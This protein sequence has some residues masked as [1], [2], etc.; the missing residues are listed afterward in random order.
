MVLEKWDGNKWEESLQ[1]QSVFCGKS[2]PGVVEEERASCEEMGSWGFA[3]LATEDSESNKI[4]S[5][6]VDGLLSK[7][8]FTTMVIGTD[9]SIPTGPQAHPQNTNERKTTNVESPSFRPMSLGS[10]TFPNM[11]FTTP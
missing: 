7:A 1:D 6:Y 10:T 4:L 9:N 2:V 11:T 5:Q 3:A 8:I